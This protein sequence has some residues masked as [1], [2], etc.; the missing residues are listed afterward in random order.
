MTTRQTERVARA[1]QS[2]QTCISTA[3]CYGRIVRS[4]SRA[5]DTLSDD[6][7]RKL[8]MV[9]GPTGL[10]GFLGK[11][12]YEMLLH[13]GY[14]LEYIVDRVE[15]G[16]QFWVVIFDRPQGG[17]RVAT[18]ANCVDVAAA[19]YPQVGTILKGAIGELRCKPFQQFQDE[20]GFSFAEVHTLGAEDPRFMTAER[21]LES[22]RSPLAVRRF[23]YHTL[24]LT[25]LYSG[26]GTTRL[27]NHSRGIREYVMKNCTVDELPELSMA[28][29]DIK[30][31]AS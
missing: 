3:G 23:L 9:T 21:L 27:H 17:V 31:P 2:G 25:E 29:L 1:L 6:A 7:A 19:T 12:P 15:S 26:D 10:R 30:L 4:R 16:C 24:R 20:A 22:D 8:V 11:S 18:W 5:P 13:I 14:T 28:R